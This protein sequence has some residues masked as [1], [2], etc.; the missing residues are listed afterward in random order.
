MVTIRINSMGKIAFDFST[1]MSFFS[2]ALHI[3]FQIFLC[4]AF[5][6]HLK[7][8]EKFNLLQF[9]SCLHNYAT[10]Q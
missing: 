3:E 9:W 1:F 8:M 10:N 2:I 6:A 4:A 5:D 7:S